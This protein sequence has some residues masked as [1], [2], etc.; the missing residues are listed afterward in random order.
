MHQRSFAR[1]AATTIMALAALVGVTA[2]IAPGAEAA[3]NRR[4]CVYSKP[5]VT[6]NN[7]SNFQWAMN[8]KKDG[9]CPENNNRASLQSTARAKSYYKITCEEYAQWIRVKFDPCPNHM[10]TDQLVYIEWSLD[11]KTATK[12]S[13]RGHY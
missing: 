4:V 2:I 7:R 11:G 3:A 13:P 12:F 10:P 1:R 8:F 6:A 5:D 9:G